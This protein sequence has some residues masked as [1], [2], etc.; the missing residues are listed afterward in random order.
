MANDSV[1][2]KLVNLVNM[3]TIAAKDL[4]EI[5]SDDE[6][7]IGAQVDILDTLDLL[8]DRI[9]SVKKALS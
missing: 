3:M 8:E 7:G 5:I 4:N 1:A 2:D 6:V 9:N